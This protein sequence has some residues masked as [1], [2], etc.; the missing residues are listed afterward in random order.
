[1]EKNNLAEFCVRHNNVIDVQETIRSIEIQLNELVLFVANLE[2]NI[3]EAVHKVFDGYEY[4]TI[5]MPAL[6]SATL[7]H[8]G[9][10]PEKFA[11]TSQAVS[12]FIRANANEFKVTKGK[13]GGVSKI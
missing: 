12:E 10:T 7:Y 8:L 5:T 4:K 3:R 11:S 9:V 13:G 1:M 2:R 6:I